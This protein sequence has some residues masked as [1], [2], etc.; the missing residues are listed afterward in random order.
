MTRIIASHT[1]S[2]P[3]CALECNSA[4]RPSYQN[5]PL[6]VAASI[7]A[8]IAARFWTAA[9]GLALFV[10]A[11]WPAFAQD[12][13]TY[14]PSRLT[15]LTFAGTAAVAGPAAEATSAPS[16]RSDASNTSEVAARSLASPQGLSDL[17]LSPLRNDLAGHPVAGGEPAF[18]LERLPKAVRRADALQALIEAQ[19]NPPPP[20]SV[21]EQ[22][23]SLSP[24]PTP[25]LTPPAIS[26]AAQPGP[27]V[28]T[29]IGDV[30]L[31]ENRRLKTAKSAAYWARYTE[32]L[33]PLIN[34]DFNFLNLETVV[35]DRPLRA[36]SKAFAFQTHDT[37][38]AHL[39][40]DLGFNLFS[41]AN[42]HSG[43][44]RRAGQ[45]ATLAALHQH[46]PDAI[47]HGLG[48]EDELLNVREFE[49]N[50][51]TIAYAAIGISSRAPRPTGDQPG[52]FFIRRSQDWDA[53]IAAFKR[54]SAELKILSVHEGREK[55]SEVESSLKRK[56]R[57]AR[58]EAGVDLIVGHHPHVVRALERDEQ[59]RL[60]AYSLGNGLL[61]GAANIDNRP[62]G[63]DFGLFL[64]LHYWFDGKEIALEAVEGVALRGMHNKV[65][66]RSA[67][68]SARRFGF[69]N[70]LSRRTAGKSALEFAI[71]SDGQGLWCAASQQSPRAQELCQASR[72]AAADVPMPAPV[73]KSRSQSQ[74]RRSSK[75][76][77]KKRSGTVFKRTAN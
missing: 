76:Q 54:S 60:I 28:L 34:G 15:T 39:A 12:P 51:I 29:M 55:V 67:R 36:R 10:G 38:L 64:R 44:F 49:H 62:M 63:R 61:F 32:D 17:G 75:S 43:D 21:Q 23:A 37:A 1:R 59:G 26:K 40:Q 72:S 42:N 70:K 57:K 16:A 45:V 8:P 47:Y 50:G 3:V 22:L 11:S 24:A 71:T 56:L 46:A 74:T 4:Q 77:S 48:T 41:L 19:D 2:D 9:V 31:A 13:A 69:L 33:A 66:P 18:S 25:S 7:A 20:P 5:Q 30:G 65:R 53:V 27:L 58:D 73:T 52:Q 68:R 14:L 35:T 6:S